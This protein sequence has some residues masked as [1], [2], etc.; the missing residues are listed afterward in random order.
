[1]AKPRP[2]ATI[3]PA[4]NSAGQIDAG[5]TQLP[6]ASCADSLPRPSIA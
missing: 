1:M 2:T 3:A 4:A 6:H 5:G